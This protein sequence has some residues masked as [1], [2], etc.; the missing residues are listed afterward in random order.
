[1][2]SFRFAL[3]RLSFIALLAAQPVLAERPPDG[4]ARPPIHVKPFATTS[5]TGISPVQIRHAYGFDLIANQGAG[6]TIGIVDAYDDPN[7]EADLAVFNKTFGLPPCTTNNGCFQKMYAS[8]VKPRADAGWALEIALDVEWAHAIAPQARILL[9][10]AASNSFSDLLAAVDVAV[11][12]GASVVSMSFG[13]SEF[14]SETFYDSHF[15]AVGVTFTAS[16]GDSGNGAEYPAASP[17]V[18]SVGGTRLNIDGAGNYIGETAWSG[19]GGGQSGYQVEPLYQ[20]SYPIPNDPNGKRGIPDVAYD[21]DPTT[22][23]PVYD[24]VRYQGRA[25]WFQVGGTSAGSPQWAALF[26]IVNSMRAAAGK[27]PLSN[28]N[29]AVYAVA[30]ANYKDVV[31]GTNGSCVTL[32]TAVSGYDYVT[33]L[34]SPQANYVIPALVKQP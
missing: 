34:G 5:P 13:G 1:M 4:Y 6:Q 7:I 30:A 10:E 24:T 21:G 8:G 14:S 27:S 11:F 19:S 25:G 28:T 12:R 23:F 17:F 9:V 26:A 22:G 32:C 29:I 33:G 2:Q 18:V 3:I 20:A 15:T 16:S 31:I